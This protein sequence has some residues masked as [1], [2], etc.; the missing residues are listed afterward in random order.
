MGCQIQENK[1]I[2]LY[3]V[4]LS[5]SVV[6]REFSFLSIIWLFWTICIAALVQNKTGFWRFKPCFEQE[7]ELWMVNDWVCICVTLILNGQPLSLHG[8]FLKTVLAAAK[9]LIVASLQERPYSSMRE[10]KLMFGPEL[11]SCDNNEQ[12]LYNEYT[13]KLQHKKPNHTNKKR[14]QNQNKKLWCCKDMDGL[15]QFIFSKIHNKVLKLC[16]YCVF[17]FHVHCFCCSAPLCP[18]NSPLFYEC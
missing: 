13:H 18:H 14:H 4:Y 7:T 12:H 2:Q 15:I 6:C 16:F 3:F 5:M 8:H 10:Q 11:H 1:C 9:A 17:P